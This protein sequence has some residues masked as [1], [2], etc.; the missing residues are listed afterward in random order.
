MKISILSHYIQLK[1]TVEDLEQFSS[2]WPCFGTPVPIEVEI[3][4]RNGDV[5]NISP[6]VGMDEQGVN[7]LI[8]DCKQFV[9]AFEKKI[10]STPSQSIKTSYNEIMEETKGMY[11]IYT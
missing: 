10:M 4:K 8:D 6:F 5:V 9:G 3:D 11:A 2:T 7:C 1:I